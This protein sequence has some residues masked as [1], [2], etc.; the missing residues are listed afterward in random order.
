MWVSLLTATMDFIHSHSPT[1]FINCSPEWSYSRALLKSVFDSSRE[2]KKQ[3]LIS[4][5]RRCYCNRSKKC[6]ILSCLLNASVHFGSLSGPCMSEVSLGSP[7]GVGWLPFT[8]ALFSRWQSPPW[9]SPE[10]SGRKNR[11]QKTSKVL[12]V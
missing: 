9:L 12:R 10:R 7:R 5:F 4:P 3:K 8:W 11:D 2:L 6:F 1:L